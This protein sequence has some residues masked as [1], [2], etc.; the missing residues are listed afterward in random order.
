MSDLCY[1]RKPRMNRFWCPLFADW[2]ERNNMNC[3]FRAE[4]IFLGFKCL[5]LSTENQT[6]YF[7]VGPKWVIVTYIHLMFFHESHQ[8]ISILESDLSVLET[9]LLSTYILV[10]MCFSV[11]YSRKVPIVHTNWHR[12]YKTDYFR[13]YIILSMGKFNNGRYN[14]CKCAEIRTVDF[15]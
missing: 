12:Y 9:D 14:H 10:S 8:M 7:V 11:M 3:F 4:Y 1:L 2:L 5:E 15:I 13:S 6:S